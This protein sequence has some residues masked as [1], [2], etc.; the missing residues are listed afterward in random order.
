MNTKSDELVAELRQAISMKKAEVAKL[1]EECESSK[2]HLALLASEIAEGR[3]KESANRLK[4]ATLEADKSV[5][6]Q[7]EKLDSELIK[8]FDDI[9]KEMSA[10]NEEKEKQIVGLQLEVEAAKDIK[11]VISVY[12]ETLEMLRTMRFGDS[13]VISNTRKDIDRARQELQILSDEVQTFEANEKALNDKL[14]FVAYDDIPLAVKRQ[15]Y[16]DLKK[17]KGELVRKLMQAR[18]SRSHL[19]SRCSMSNL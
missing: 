4:I 11:S 6:M 7:I 2:K 13:D 16:Q 9:C 14:N 18:L 17:R 12:Q 10:A 1:K 15:V 8:K 19:D 3:A 5:C